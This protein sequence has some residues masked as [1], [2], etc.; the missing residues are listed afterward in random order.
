MEREVYT[1]GKERTGERMRIKEILTYVVGFICFLSFAYFFL[2][3]L[4]DGGDKFQSIFISIALISSIFL[5]LMICCG[6]AEADISLS[7]RSKK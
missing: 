3:K 2:F 1:F 4:A 6:W 5:M 7:E